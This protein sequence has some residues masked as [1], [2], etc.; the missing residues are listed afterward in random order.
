MVD[1]VTPNLADAVTAA[2][3]QAKL[4]KQFAANAEGSATAAAGAAEDEVLNHFYGLFAADPSSRPDE[5]ASVDGDI[6]Y[7]TV[8]RVLRMRIDGIWQTVATSVAAGSLAGALLAVNNLADIPDRA[9][10]RTSLGLGTAATL[11]AG[12]LDGVATLDNSGTVPA[13]QLNIAG[14]GGMLKSSNLNDVTSVSSAR[15]NLQLGT[16]ATK[17]SGSANGVAALDSG[18]KVPVSQL[19]AGTASGIATLD[20]SGH[21]PFSQLNA[22][23]PSGI[24]TLTAGGLVTATQLPGTVS[25]ISIAKSADYT[26]VSGDS[27][28]VISV[29]TGSSADVSITLVGAGTA[30]DGATMVVAKVDT[31][32]KKTIVKDSDGATHRAW[33]TNQWDIVAFRSNGSVWTPY[34]SQISPRIDSYTST[35]ASTW[36]KPPLTTRVLVKARGA[37]GGGQGG[38][39]I[40]S[41]ADI[42]GGQGGGGGAYIDKMFAAS[43][44]ASTESINVG[45]GGNFGAAGGFS[46]VGGGYSSFGTTI[47]VYVGGGNGG[48]SGSGQGGGVWGASPNSGSGVAGS[49]F[50]GGGPPTAGDGLS[51][52]Y[53]GAGGGQTQS[54]TARKGGSS[55][56]GGGG[57]GAGGARVTGTAVAGGSGGITG[58]LTAGGGGAGGDTSGSAGTAGNAVGVGGGGGGFSGVTAGTA[59]AGAAGGV[60][61]GGGGGGSQSGAVIGAGGAGGAGGRGQVDVISFFAV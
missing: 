7:N 56:F 61:A 12:V 57:G 5:S 19:P 58:S 10:A 44:L 3:L 34:W 29:T 25:P 60:G 6:Y 1:V 14:A 43:D 51:A 52:I 9:G 21:V 15:A 11:D 35:G 49:G 26:T 13:A 40:G 8:S 24:A 38:S 48:G 39:G 32:S 36:T 33:L 20:S 17:D 31:G 23:N 2:L 54:A 59:G 30:G 50:E 55:G 22:G 16:A 27:G 53:G 42:N 4:A 46:G 18:G 45:V 37:G 47:K 28:K 41:S